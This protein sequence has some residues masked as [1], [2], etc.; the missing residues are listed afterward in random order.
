MKNGFVLV[1]NMTLLKSAVARSLV[2]LTLI[3]L[4]SLNAVVAAKLSRGIKEVFSMYGVWN[5]MQKR[6]VFGIKETSPRRAEKA[7][8]HRIGKSAYKWRYSIKKIPS[9]WRNPPNPN[10]PRK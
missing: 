2:N 1:S 8:F 5:D 4:T 3:L 9:N 6:F 10:W 7:L